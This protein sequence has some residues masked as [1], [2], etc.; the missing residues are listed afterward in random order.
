MPLVHHL[1]RM[2]STSAAVVV[3][4]ST[5]IGPTGHRLDSPW[6]LG[7]YTLDRLS[8]SLLSQGTQLLLLVCS[9]S[10]SHTLPRTAPSSPA[11]A[12]ALI[13]L[14]HSLRTSQA[15]R[16]NQPTSTETGA[17]II[18]RTTHRARKK[19]SSFAGVDFASK[20]RLGFAEP[21]PSGHLVRKISCTVLRSLGFFAHPGNKWEP[22]YLASSRNGSTHPT[23]VVH[24]NTPPLPLP[25][26][27]ASRTRA[28]LDRGD[29]SAEIRCSPMSDTRA[30]LL[31]SPR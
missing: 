13:I 15:A 28:P 24:I 5:R 18:H 7:M 2:H 4:C 20:D 19:Q 12:L 3:A 31:R 21:H 11:P 23:P 17:R 29:P 9:F 14:P 10:F 25:S 8:L 30:A 1:G 27:A 26:Q 22:L 6:P 16:D